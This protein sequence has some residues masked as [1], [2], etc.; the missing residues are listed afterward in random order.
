[1]GWFSKK[2]EVPRLPPAPELPDLPEAPRETIRSRNELPALPPTDLGKNLN[3]EMVK[4]AVTDLENPGATIPNLPPPPSDSQGKP[5]IPS[6]AS[7]PNT[8]EE[9]PKQQHRIN[10]PEKSTFEISEEP[11]EQP[12]TRPADSIFVKIEDFQDA[13]KDFK[14]ITTKIKQI[15]KVLVKVRDKKIKEDEE[16]ADWTDEIE[17]TKSKLSEI[18]SEIFSKI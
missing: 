3:Q 16:I 15:E 7:L 18:D 11:Q 5:M 2:E 9:V 4:S 10:V 17:K 6:I 8:A 13:Q 1:M 12:I 14:E